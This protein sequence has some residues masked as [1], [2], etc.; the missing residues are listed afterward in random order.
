MDV[1]VESSVSYILIIIANGMV[2]SNNNIRSNIRFDKILHRI[3]YEVTANSLAVLAKLFTDYI[4]GTK[5]IT[6]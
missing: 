3:I 5:Y 6:L 4:T 1:G 2:N